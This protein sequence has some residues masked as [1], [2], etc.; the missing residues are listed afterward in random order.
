M[1]LLNENIFNK[2]ELTKVFSIK[3]I[4]HW[5]IIHPDLLDCTVITD[6]FNLAS[7]DQVVDRPGL[8][9][10]WDIPLDHEIFQRRLI[11][12]QLS[13]WGVHVFQHRNER[14]DEERTDVEREQIGEGEEDV[15]AEGAGVVGRRVGPLEQH[16]GAPREREHLS[17]DLM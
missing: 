10:G 15:L 1:N 8:E 12:F 5:E 4:V 7:P 2:S 9:Y 14:P 13:L 6:Y 16:R 11:F 17:S 3:C